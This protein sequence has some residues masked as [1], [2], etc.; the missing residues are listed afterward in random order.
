MEK[1]CSKAMQEGG[2]SCDGFFLGQDLPLYRGILIVLAC[3]TWQGKKLSGFL[4]LLMEKDVLFYLFG[5][6]KLLRPRR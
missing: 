4:T 6:K 2:M 1:V 3:H 5:S